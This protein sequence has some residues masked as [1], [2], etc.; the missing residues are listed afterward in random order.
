MKRDFILILSSSWKM[1][2]RLW[3]NT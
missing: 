3:Y 1:F 2:Y